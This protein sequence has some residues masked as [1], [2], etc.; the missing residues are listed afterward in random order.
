[1]LG[2]CCVIMILSKLFSA[3][4]WQILVSLM[5]WQT[6]IV[7]SSAMIQVALFVEIEVS[8]NP[9]RTQSEAAKTPSTAP[10]AIWKTSR[11]VWSFSFEPEKF[12]SRNNGFPACGVPRMTVIVASMGRSLGFALKPRGI[13]N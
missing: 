13:R 7:S 8:I 10:H 3:L 5:I 2:N 4:S 11:R 6:G 9:N 12:K 1:M